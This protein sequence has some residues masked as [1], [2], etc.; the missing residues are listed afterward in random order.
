MLSRVVHNHCL[1]FTKPCDCRLSS[2]KSEG[3]TQLPNAAHGT[4][5]IC[6]NSCFSKRRVVRKWLSTHNLIR[7]LASLSA[8][9]SRTQFAKANFNHQIYRQAHLPSRGTTSFDLDKFGGSTLLTSIALGIFILSSANQWLAREMLDWH[10]RWSKVVVRSDKSIYPRKG[11]GWSDEVPATRFLLDKCGL[12]SP[13]RSG[14]RQSCGSS[15]WL[16][17]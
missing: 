2:G 8:S 10:A 17:I 11:A 12:I 9:S 3:V 4:A 14:C 13:D 1:C 15:A 6:C 16:V 7:E 5:N